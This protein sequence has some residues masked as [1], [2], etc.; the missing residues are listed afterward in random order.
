M[1]CD[2]APVNMG[3]VP[4]HLQMPTHLAPFSLPPSA[5]LS[6]AGMCFGA[7]HEIGE[8]CTSPVTAGCRCP[9]SLLRAQGHQALGGEAKSLPTG[10]L[11]ASEGSHPGPQGAHEPR[12][13]AAQVF[14]LQPSTLSARCFLDRLV[15]IIFQ[16][17]RANKRKPFCYE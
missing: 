11:G 3:G 17:M 16:E 9:M 12:V 10:V 1:C 2:I 13:T 4:K 5:P 15:L 14:F 7:S 6:P 8:V